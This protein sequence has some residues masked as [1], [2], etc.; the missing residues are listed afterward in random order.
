MRMAESSENGTHNN[1]P[2]WLLVGQGTYFLATGLWSLVDI[3]SF[4]RVTGP[5]TDVWL[6]KTVGV[7][8]TVIGAALLEAGRRGSPSREI[9]ML[10]AGS[11]AGLT[12]IDV[13]YSAKGTIS[14]IYLLDAALEAGIIG[15]H[16]GRIARQSGPNRRQDP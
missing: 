11:A 16:L 3:R 8:V 14:P 7:L 9:K 5:K 12:G 1:G 13:I 4:Q 2:D 10:A 15:L 6:V